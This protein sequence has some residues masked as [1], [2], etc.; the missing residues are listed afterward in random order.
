M[1]SFLAGVER[2]EPQWRDLLASVVGGEG[3]GGLEIENVYPAREPG[4]K[5]VI[6]VCK[7]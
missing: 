2:T 5:G 1:M 3:G 7:R 6:E 4:G